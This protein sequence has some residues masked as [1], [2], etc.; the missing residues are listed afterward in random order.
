MR[1]LSPSLEEMLQGRVREMGELGEEE[2]ALMQ[3]GA[4]VKS[5]EKLGG[6]STSP[7]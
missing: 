7:C 3:K 5:L 6:S 2:G 1:L 4:E